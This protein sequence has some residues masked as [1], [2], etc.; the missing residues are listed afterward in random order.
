MPLRARLTISIA[1][2]LLVCLAFDSSFVY[3]HVVGKVDIEVGAGPAVG[4]HTV[5]NAVADGRAV[6][7]CG[8]LESLAKDFNEDRHLRGSLVDDTSATIMASTPSS[9]P[10][11]ASRWSH[12]LLTSTSMVDRVDIPS[13]VQWPVGC[14]LGPFH[15]LPAAFSRI[16]DG[17]YARRIAEHRPLELVQIC[18]GFNQMGRHLGEIEAR[19]G[20]LAEQL[21]VVQEEEQ[22]DLAVDL[23][24]EIGSLLF[25]V[26]VNVASITEHKKLRSHPVIA[27]GI[28][29][30]RDAVGQMQKDVRSILRRLRPTTLLDLVAARAVDDS[31]A[32]G[33]GAA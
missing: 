11:P 23:N 13:I 19:N 32:R 12:R 18:R 2:V 14:A 24:D 7:V 5:E 8:P 29:A 3:W 4:A 20:Y 31:S 6:R 15:D 28:D 16:G 33:S 27:P 9:P 22:S 30:I 21:A 26:S 25:A 17:D 10:E 1:T